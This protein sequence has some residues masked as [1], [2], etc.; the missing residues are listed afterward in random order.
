[1]DHGP[2]HEFQAVILAGGNGNR[3]FPLTEGI[4]K[5]MLPIGNIPMIVY[6]LA[7]LERVKFS[8]VIIIAQ[9]SASKAIRHSVEEMLSLKIKLIFQTIPNESDMGTADAL[10]L[11]KDKIYTDFL[12]FSCDLVSN[13]DIRAAVDIHRLNDASVTCLFVNPPP[14]SEADR[15]LQK[16]KSKNEGV[17]N[18]SDY[19]LL[20]PTTNRI[21][22]FTSQAD[23]EE[24]VLPFRKVLFDHHPVIDMHTDLLDTHFYIFAKWVI[25]FLV[26]KK[27]IT[28]IKGEL[29]P[30]LVHKQFSKKKNGILDPFEYV[31]TSRRHNANLIGSK[32]SHAD[33]QGGCNSSVLGHTHG[34]GASH[35]TEASLSRTATALEAGEDDDESSVIVSGFRSA[36]VNAAR[37][38]I[39]CFA[40]V[41][42]ATTLDTP[43]DSSRQGF[44][45]RANTLQR[46]MDINKMLPKYLPSLLNDGAERPLVHPD[47]KISP[48]T[49]VGNDS[50]V[51]AFTV[52]EDKCSIKKSV[53]G[54]HCSIGERCKISNSVIMDHVTIKAGSVL[55][56]CIVCHD[57]HISQDANLTNC[58][59]GRSFTVAP[60]TSAKNEALTSDESFVQ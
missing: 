12:V 26:E 58:Q 14:M 38:A 54:T 31:N 2:R 37:T 34:P 40:H 29:L 17:G 22:G 50:M 56:N 45:A 23:L 5:A 20:D 32:P 16:K 44:A 13:I 7:T 24:D 53:I 59:V 49:Q 4:P 51:G 10:R 6:T 1:M 47:A 9:E 8:S 41:V 3:M 21:V 11:I 15:A 36:R 28:T 27:S 55:S 19:I 52:I 39:K 35:R 42:E 60:A 46:Y 30:Y 48:R 43:D 57:A 25:D 18:L 33:L